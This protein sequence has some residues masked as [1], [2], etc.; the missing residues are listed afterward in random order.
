MGH[1]P[2]SPVTMLH[3]IH[4]VAEDNDMSRG[5]DGCDFRGSKLKF[6]CPSCD[7]IG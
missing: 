3:Y 1:S 2:G 6:L 7:Q 4:P 5:A